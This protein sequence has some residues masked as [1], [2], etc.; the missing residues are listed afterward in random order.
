MKTAQTPFVMWKLRTMRG[1]DDGLPTGGVKACRTTRLGG[2][3]RTWHFD[4]LPQLWNVLL[5]DMSLVGPRPPTAQAVSH[6]PAEFGHI[7]EMRPG[8]TGLATIAMGREERNALAGLSTMAEVEQ[9]YMRQILP[10]KL[11]IE[12][13]YL[14]TWSIGLDVWI[15][16]RTF[17]VILSPPAPKTRAA[18]PNWDGNEAGLRRTHATIPSSHL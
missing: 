4:E 10:C 5:G 17:L 1:V 15:L 2:M 8:M 16:L 12:R 13:Q 9:V 14:E 7:L 6:S 11:R 3:L 18:D